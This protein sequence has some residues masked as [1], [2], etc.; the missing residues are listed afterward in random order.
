MLNALAK[1]EGEILENDA[2]IKTLESIKGKAKTIEDA[3]AKADDTLEKIEEVSSLYK[4]LSTM[5]TR[6]FFTLDTLGSIDR[7]YQFQL[8]TFMDI[9]YQV[10]NEDPILKAIS[11]AQYEQRLRTIIQQLFITINQQIGQGLK[12]EHHLLF[13]MRLAQIK[14]SEDPVS[15]ELFDLWLKS[16]ISLEPVSMSAS[17]FDNRLTKI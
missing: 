10:L 13:S 6:V 3:M 1:S 2:L 5:T 11:K 15:E 8:K 12:Q 14:L 4:P 7:L 17:L 9:I 16:S